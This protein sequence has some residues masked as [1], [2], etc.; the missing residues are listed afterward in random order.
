MMRRVMH[1]QTPYDFRPAHL[2]DLPMLQRWRAAPHVRAWWDSDEPQTPEE[3]ADTRERRW[4]VS[5]EGC[6]FAY[7]QD[8]TVH[9]WAEH[10]FYDLPHGARGIDQFIGLPEMVGRGHGPAF[11]KLRLAQMFAEGAPCIA[12]DPHPDNRHAISAY[13]KAGFAPTGPAQDTPWGLIMPMQATP[14]D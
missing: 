12:T 5:H 10:P 8:Y 2:S 13:E 4:I 7:M 14:K 9:G 1:P 3:F 11:I 6:P